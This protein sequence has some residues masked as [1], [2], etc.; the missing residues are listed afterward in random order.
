MD[1]VSSSVS[2]KIVE[3]D[4][5][6]FQKM[7]FIY[8]ALEKGWQIKKESGSYVFTKKHENRREIFK[9]KYLDDFINSN[10]SL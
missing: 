10:L 7:L 4:K 2:S 9:E 8:N 3:I 6:K 1:I 5:K